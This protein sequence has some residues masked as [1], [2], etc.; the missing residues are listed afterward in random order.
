MLDSRK[1][2]LG[3]AQYAAGAA[4]RNGIEPL[5]VEIA[6]GDVVVAG[7]DDELSW[8]HIDDEGVISGAP[9]CGIGHDTPI[10][11]CDVGATGFV[12]TGGADGLVR[13]WSPDLRDIPVSSMHLDSEVTVLR[14]SVDG[15]RLAMGTTTGG[16][17]IADVVSGELV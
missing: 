3:V 8:W 6:F 10:T 7:S 14:W 12:A 1:L 17:V 4:F 15:E 16:L 13:L 9:E 11:C 5:I 2:Q